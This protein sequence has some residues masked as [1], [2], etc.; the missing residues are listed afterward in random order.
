MEIKLTKKQKE[1]IYQAKELE[2]EF[3]EGNVF[4]SWVNEQ[5][6]VKFIIHVKGETSYKAILYY[7]INGTVINSLQKKGLLTCCDN[8]HRENVDP[9][10][11]RK[12]PEDW[13]CVGSRI[14]MELVTN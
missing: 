12:Q 14:K 3:G 11:W 4:L 9:N 5:L 10:N 1:I 2:K 13:F 8:M 7:K 6:K